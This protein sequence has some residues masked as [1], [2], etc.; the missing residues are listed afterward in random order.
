MAARAQDT[1][2]R[3]TRQCVE[4]PVTHPVSQKPAREEALPAE[5]AVPRAAVLIVHGMGQQIEFE[6]LENVDAGLLQADAAA[7]KKPAEPRPRSIARAVRL[8]EE[9]LQRVELTLTAKDGSEREVH[10]YEAYWAP[11]TE[12]VVTLRD[13]FRFL[14]RAT[15]NGIVNGWTF[16]RWMFGGL[17]GF[18][19]H[20][21]TTFSLLLVLSVVLSLFL[22]N[23]VVAVGF[24]ARILAG[25]ESWVWLSEAFLADLTS[26]VGLL[27][28]MA[29]VCALF[30]SMVSSARAWI[31]ADPRRRIPWSVRLATFLFYLTFG[32]TLLLGILAGPG[33]VLLLILHRSGLDDVLWP[34][35][36]ETLA[37]GWWGLLV[38]ILWVGFA[39]ASHRLRKILIQYVGDVAAYI[40]PDVL[41]RFDDLRRQIQ[42][43]VR[44][45]AHAIYAARSKSGREH[46]YSRIAIVGHSLGSVIGYDTLNRLLN[47]DDLS[48]KKEKVLERTCL[49]LTVGSPL[50]KTAYI[51][52]K[53]ARS[54]WVTRAALAATVQPLIQDYANRTFRWVNVY[55]P[56]DVFSGKLRFYDDKSKPGFSRHRVR[57]RRDRDAVTPF[58]AHNEYWKS[59]TMFAHLHEALTR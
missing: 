11:M 41:D 22:I 25:R 5:G 33:S 42:Q 54:G 6:T 18:R 47:E 20:R 52:A 30:F 26:V 44:R 17:V 46:E 58:A 55:S 31:A 49:L 7:K 37:P 40:S 36:F 39:W 14:V 34:P 2:F 38:A 32:L 57:N 59:R 51:F 10:L 16:Q 13:V 35:S 45:T 56:H 9:R 12:G 4:K 1:T 48:G 21:S 19:R 3:A 43:S 23:S 27:V 8:G 50:D 24:A 53:K 15:Y 28:G 29:A